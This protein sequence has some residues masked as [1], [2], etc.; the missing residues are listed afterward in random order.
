MGRNFSL[1]NCEG[2]QEKDDD[3]SQRNTRGSFQ[4]GFLREADSSGEVDADH[5]AQALQKQQLPSG[6]MKP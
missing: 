6:P 5:Y 3:C 4:V 1:D 2:N